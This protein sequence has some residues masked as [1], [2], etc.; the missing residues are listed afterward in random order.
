MISSMPPAQ[1][2]LGRLFLSVL[3]ISIGCLGISLAL[4]WNDLPPQSHN[5]RRA[6]DLV[7]D[8]LGRCR[9]RCS[10]QLQDAWRRGWATVCVGLFDDGVDMRP[11]ERLADL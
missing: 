10:V 4:R 3:L 11:V 7:V 8:D 2:S 9:A 1:F 6:A 5:H